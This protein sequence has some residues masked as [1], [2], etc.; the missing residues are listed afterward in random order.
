MDHTD[1]LLA[2][3]ASRVEHDPSYSPGLSVLIE[4]VFVSGVVTSAASF[5]AALRLTGPDTP[6]SADTP[7]QPASGALPTYL[8]L[9]NVKFYAGSGQQI[10]ERAG[11]SFWRCRLSAISGFKLGTLHYLATRVGES[12]VRRRLTEA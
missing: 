9:R 11:E 7:G 3:I 12:E 1:V 5:R 10:E 6:E 8:H 4:G 2:E